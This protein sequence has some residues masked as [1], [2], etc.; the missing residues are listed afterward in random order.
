M[1]Y[2]SLLAAVFI[3]VSF[4]GCALANDTPRHTADEVIMV[5][6]GFSSL[7]LVQTGE[8]CS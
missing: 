1:R 8:E 3:L 5:A 7:C 2:V 6:K 4:A